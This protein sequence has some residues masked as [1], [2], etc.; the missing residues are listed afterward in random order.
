MERKMGKKFEVSLDYDPEKKT[1][2]VKYNDII[3]KDG[4]CV[5]YDDL[6]TMKDIQEFAR[7]F[8]LYLQEKA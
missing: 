4:I 1:L 8:L 6:L 3:V 7:G 2:D 5:M